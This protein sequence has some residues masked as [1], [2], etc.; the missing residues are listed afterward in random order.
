[1]KAP[2]QNEKWDHPSDGTWIRKGTHLAESGEYVVISRTDDPCR[3]L[4]WAET[5]I[6]AMFIVVDLEKKPEYKLT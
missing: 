1:L 5:L 6:D 4:G 2:Y 3:A